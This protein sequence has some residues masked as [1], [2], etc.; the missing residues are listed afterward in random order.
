[1]YNTFKLLRKGVIGVSE[2][3]SLVS[4]PSEVPEKV[5]LGWQRARKTSGGG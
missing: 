4:T 1:M 2:F 3:I 5:A